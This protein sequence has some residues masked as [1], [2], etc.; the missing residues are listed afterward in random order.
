MVEM[1]QICLNLLL[2]ALLILHQNVNSFQRQLSQLRL[3]HSKIYLSQEK[4]LLSLSLIRISNE[5]VLES[6]SDGNSNEIIAVG[7]PEEVAKVKKSYT[8]KYLAPLL[9]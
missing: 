2:L 4:S 6:T 9:K 7:T 5:E 8:G 1:T 3:Q